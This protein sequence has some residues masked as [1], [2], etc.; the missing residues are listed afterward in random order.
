MTTHQVRVRITVTTAHPGQDVGIVAVDADRI[1][2]S[3]VSYRVYTA[4][5]PKVPTVTSARVLNL[6]VHP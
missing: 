5:G 1:P 4:G 3:A 2:L 6:S